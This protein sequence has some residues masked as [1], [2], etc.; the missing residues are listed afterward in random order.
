MIWLRSLFCAHYW[1]RYKGPITARIIAE[2]Y[3]GNMP[4]QC[5]RCG[6]LRYEQRYWIPLN[7][8]WEKG[9]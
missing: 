5:I 1:I 4:F 7:F 6:K 3:L 2:G 8:I 9:E